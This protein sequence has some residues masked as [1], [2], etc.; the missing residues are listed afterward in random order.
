M[1]KDVA[2]S[3]ED[4]NEHNRYCEAL[5]RSMAHLCQGRCGW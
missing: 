4:K 1:H 2:T 3:L 5:S